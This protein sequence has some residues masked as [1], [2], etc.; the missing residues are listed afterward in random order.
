MN[1]RVESHVGLDD[2]N[3]HHMVVQSPSMNHTINGQIQVVIFIIIIIF[4]TA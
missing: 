4:T 2:W 3:I 1:C